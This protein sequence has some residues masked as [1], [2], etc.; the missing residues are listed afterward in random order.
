M[1][2]VAK[3]CQTIIFHAKLFDSTAC[4][5]ALR[6]MERARCWT[7]KHHCLWLLAYVAQPCRRGARVDLPAQA[8][9]LR[10][11]RTSTRAFPST[12][13]PPHIKQAGL[14]FSLGLALGLG[15]RVGWVVTAVSRG[16]KNITVGKKSLY[17]LVTKRY[18]IQTSFYAGTSEAGRLPRLADVRTVTFQ[19]IRRLDPTI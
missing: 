15:F 6:P 8:N 3:S 17:R 12:T 19:T 16:E 18:L 7:L 11:A 14:S 4:C 13:A 9:F 5:S 1:I 10:C 2:H